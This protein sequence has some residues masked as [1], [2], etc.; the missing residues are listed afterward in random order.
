MLQKKK[1]PALRS[2]YNTRI[3]V[4]VDLST[5]HYDHAPS[6]GTRSVGACQVLPIASSTKSTTADIKSVRNRINRIH[7]Q[8]NIKQCFY[9]ITSVTTQAQNLQLCTIMQVR[10]S[11]RTQKTFQPCVCASHVRYLALSA[12]LDLEVTT[13]GEQS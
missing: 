6:V 1:S 5:K 12:K 8:S 4:T 11:P 9:T 3:S 13:C 10:A 2:V 7:N